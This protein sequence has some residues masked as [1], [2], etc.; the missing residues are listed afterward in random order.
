[1]S[2]R[3]VHGESRQDLAAPAGGPHRLRPGHARAARP[4]IWNEQLIRYAGYR[5][6]GVTSPTTTPTPA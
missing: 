2:S 3:A 5:S 1:M 4:R 6:A